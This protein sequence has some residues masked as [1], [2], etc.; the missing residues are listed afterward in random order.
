MATCVTKEVSCP[1]CGAV[2]KSQM[3]IEI[4]RSADPQL[5]EKLLSE[6]LFDWQCPD[7]GYRAQMVYP[8][9]YHDKKGSW[10]VCLSPA[11]RT[12]EVMQAEQH[13]P[14]LSHVKKRLVLTPAQLKEKA[15]IFERGFD[16]IALEMVK[17]ALQELTEQKRDMRVDQMYYLTDSEDLD[18][19]GFSMFLRGEEKPVYQGVRLEV[20]EK[21]LR[22][23]RRVSF[24]EEGFQQVD[25]AL[26]KTLLEH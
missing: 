7:C 8:C 15:M 4:E 19:L 14:G 13:H 1:S 24:T 5:R 12:P 18:Y 17:L 23:A 9:L 6:T 3:W 16:D 2:N 20:Y 21:S 11:G 22:A 25:L 10:M 26:A